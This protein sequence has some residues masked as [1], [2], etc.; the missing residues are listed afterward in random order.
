MFHPFRV[1]MDLANFVLGRCPRLICI[2]PACSRQAFRV[3][4]EIR[5]SSYEIFL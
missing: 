5:T 1:S 3:N 4:I 2:T